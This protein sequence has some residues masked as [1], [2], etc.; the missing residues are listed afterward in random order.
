MHALNHFR[1]TV[2]LF[3]EASADD[4]SLWAHR[5]PGF[6]PLALAVVVLYAI[7]NAPADQLEAL[8]S[9][10]WW[11][12]GWLAPRYVAP[13]V[14]VRRFVVPLKGLLFGAAVV[15]LLIPIAR[16]VARG[17]REIDRPTLRRSAWLT[18]VLLAISWALCWPYH[19]SMWAVGNWG[20]FFARMSENPFAEP[21][22]YFHRRLLKPALAYFLQFRGPLLY[23]MFTMLCTAMLSFLIVLYFEVMLTRRG[24]RDDDDVQMPDGLLRTLASLGVM[25]TNVVMLHL[26]A[27][28]YV[29]DLLAI[30]I[31]L[32]IVLPLTLKARLCLVALAMAT[33][34]AAAVFGLGPLVLVL[35]PTWTQ[36]L[37]AW[38]LMGSFFGFWL[39]SYGFD[40]RAAFGV[41]T[42]FET[43][44]T[45]DIML[46]HPRTLALGLFM[47]HKFFWAVFIAA[48]WRL[49]ARRQWAPAGALAAC[50]L[51]PLAT[52]PI[53]TDTSRLVGMGF[54]GILFAV[55]VLLPD[56]R[57]SMGRRL[58]ALACVASI[59]VPYYPSGASWFES[60]AGGYYKAAYLYVRGWF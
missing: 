26:T 42:Q 24:N 53:A 31:L 58:F 35:F 41:H 9:A 36:R 37:A 7:C 34:E 47:A 29:D 4:S 57:T 23:W 19:T 59:L 25:S 55:V 33:H 28:E 12:S 14:F 51:V 48:L 16:A 17:L 11:W 3:P 10:N 2:L 21:H 60:P 45:F 8:L 54:A 39:A 27:P 6:A 15:C 52:M 40:L 56:L 5:S 18:L 20:T 43:Q 49:L 1:R 44:S 46:A 13:D 32:Q 30:L 22:N 38:G 50:T